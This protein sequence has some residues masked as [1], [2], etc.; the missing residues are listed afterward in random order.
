MDDRDGNK[1]YTTEIIADNMQLMGRR[2]IQVP[3]P[4][5][6]RVVHLT[7]QPV[8]KPSDDVVSEGDGTDDLPF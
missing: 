6:P 4:C 8:S 7:V 3:N 1:R 2:V 5:L